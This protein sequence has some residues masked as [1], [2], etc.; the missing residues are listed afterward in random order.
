MR[1]GKRGSKEACGERE[2][3][4]N[5]CHWRWCPPGDTRVP[6]VALAVGS[7]GAR[8]TG[9]ENKKLFPESVAIMEEA[10]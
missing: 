4:L 8:D 3:H 5:H 6:R 2:Q 7:S 1:E 10:T 9:Y